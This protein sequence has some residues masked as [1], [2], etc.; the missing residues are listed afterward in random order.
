MDADSTLEE[1]RAATR[2]IPL[3]LMHMEPLDVAVDEATRARVLRDHLLYQRAIE[4]EGKLFLAGPIVSGRNEGHGL[5][6]LR[7][8]DEAE[9]Q[10][11][12]EEEPFHVE[13]IRHNRIERWLVNEGSIS[14]RIDLY[15]NTCELL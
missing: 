13:G 4:A 7:C 8:A 6:V 12:A 3:F 11:I 14:L 5:T 9:A 10:R 15:A 2:R 1:L